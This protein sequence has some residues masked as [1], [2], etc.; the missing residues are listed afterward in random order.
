MRELHIYDVHAE[1]NKYVQCVP[2]CRE[3]LRKTYLIGLR[4]V[5]E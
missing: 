3:V 4:T 5:Y 2:L 1:D